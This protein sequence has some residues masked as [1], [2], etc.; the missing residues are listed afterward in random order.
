MKNDTS[1]LI[2]TRYLG[3]I[4]LKKIIDVIME[5]KYP[6]YESLSNAPKFWKFLDNVRLF[7]NLIDIIFIVYILYSIKLNIYL[8]VVFVLL[9]ITNIFYFL[10]DERYLYAII[11][12]KNINMNTITWL[13]GFLGPIYNILALVYIIYILIQFKPIH[14]ILLSKL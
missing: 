10:V 4:I 1:Y 6:T 11:D 2:L 3:F 14:F 5:I 7:L 13:D 8:Y 12:K 9:L